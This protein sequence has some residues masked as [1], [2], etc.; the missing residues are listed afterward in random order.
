MVRVAPRWA[1]QRDGQWLGRRRDAMQQDRRRCQLHR[2]RGGL[3]LRR[4]DEP[5]RGPSG[6]PHEDSGLQ[7]QVEHRLRRLGDAGQLI[8]LQER[9]NIVG[10]LQATAEQPVRPQPGPT[11]FP[12]SE[13]SWDCRTPAGAWRRPGSVR[14][15]SRTAA[16]WRSALACRFR[17]I[18]SASERRTRRRGRCGHGADRLPADAGQ[19]V[20]DDD[21]VVLRQV[22]ERGSRT[23]RATRTRP[24][25]ATRWRSAASERSSDWR[26]AMPAS[27]PGDEELRHSPPASSVTI[28]W[29]STRCSSQHRPPMKVAGRQRGSSWRR[30]GIVDRPEKMC[31]S[32]PPGCRTQPPARGS[33]GQQV[34]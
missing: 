20:R 26:C 2:L 10:R 16:P 24:G 34:N 11:T 28:R 32:V 5:G 29:L 14:G 12:D 33:A 3:Q 19:E 1:D 22:L 4:Q 25:R 30:A 7:Q 21:A 18:T 8:G 17:S 9:L 15:A 23:T 31:A 27:R 6:L 13:T